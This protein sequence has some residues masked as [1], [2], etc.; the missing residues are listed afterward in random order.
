M[1]ELHVLARNRNKTIV[2][3]ASNTKLFTQTEAMN[4][5]VKMFLI[6][7]DNK[8]ITFDLHDVYNE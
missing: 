7:N 1:L 5:K 2:K 4:L 8:V 6:P 3:G